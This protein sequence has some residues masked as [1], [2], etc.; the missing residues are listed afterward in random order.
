M[1]G[2]VRWKQRF[3]NALKALE[4]LSG[5][6]RLAGER[7]LTP[8][9]EQGVVQ[10]FEFTH[11]LAWNVLKDY[12]EYKGVSDV[13]GSWGAVRQAFRNGLLED[14]E[15]WMAMIRDRSLTSHTTT[16]DHCETTAQ[17]AETPLHELRSGLNLVLTRRCELGYNLYRC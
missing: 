6:A 4:T 3:D 7:R 10:S 14:G 5:A 2:D 9:E 8:L 15:S 11:E 13:I 12:L 16:R 1:T 17:F